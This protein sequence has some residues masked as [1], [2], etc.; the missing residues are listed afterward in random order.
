MEL[1]CLGRKDVIVINGGTNDIHAKSQSFRH[2]TLVEIGSKRK[3]FTKHGL[4]LN[5][6]GKEWLAKLIAT[7]IEKFINNINKIE[8]VIALN[9]IEETT[10]MSINVTDNHKPNLLFSSVQF[11][12]FHQI[13]YK[14]K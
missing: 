4:H 14:S 6:A 11:I 12:Q 7:Q 9:W 1:M 3:H 2:V 13:H 5:N 10:N 8:P